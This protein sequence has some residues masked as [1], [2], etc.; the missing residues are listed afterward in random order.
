MRSQTST[1]Y[2]IILAVVIIIALIVVSTLGGIPGMGGGASHSAQQAQLEYLPIGITDYAVGCR[3]TSLTLVNNQPSTIQVL[4]L[5]I[6]GVTCQTDSAIL[7]VGERR[8]IYCPQ[9]ISHASGEAFE[10]QTSIGWQD[11]QTQSL[12]TQEPQVRMVGVVAS[13][14]CIPCSKLLQAL[15]LLRNG[16]EDYADDHG[17]DF[18]DL[19]DIAE[20]LTMRT[21]IDGNIEGSGVGGPYIYGPYLSQIPPQPIEGFSEGE[22]GFTS[23]LG[24]FG[25]GWFYYQVAGHIYGNI[26]DSAE[27]PDGK[28]YNQY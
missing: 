7:N 13:C 17:G 16:V 8:L 21:D 23:T 5:T 12:Y 20:Q 28:R 27:D 2:L 26:G 24:T 4:D 15:Y 11:Q 18:P 1:E 6:N 22:T 14:N 25:A 3:N 9:L 10:Y 19:S